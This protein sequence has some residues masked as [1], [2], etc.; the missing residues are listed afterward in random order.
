MKISQTL[1]QPENW[2]DFESLCLLL[3]RAEWNSEDLK[4]NGRNGQ[5]QKGVDIC[6]HRDGENEYS[7]IQCKCKPGNKA[8]TTNEIDEEIANAQQF[9]PAIRRLIFATTADKDAT[10]EEYVRIKDDE[11]R[12]KGLFSIDIKSWQDIVDLLERNKN[13]LNTYLDIVAEDY[14]VAITFDNGNEETVI[15]PKFSRFY[16][17]EP[18]V[19][20]SSIRSVE[21]NAATSAIS[22][23]ALGGLAAQTEVLSAMLKNHLTPV[24]ATAR[25]VRGHIKT[26]HAF[27]PL[28]LQI[29]NQGRA[30]IDDYKVSFYF[31]NKDV[32]F[33]KSNVEKKTVM[34]EI[35]YS[36]GVSNIAL[37]NGVGLRMFGSSIIPGDRDFSD[38]F[39]VHFPEDVKEVNIV[40]KL[41]SRQYSME[42]KLRILV[43]CMFE[44]VVRYNK[45]KA[46][47]TVI[48]DFIER[49]DIEA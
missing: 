5:A 15:R 26:N 43:E 6:G 35:R 10:I 24:K 41:L 34:P 31:D 47:E 46:G 42:G 48:E 39:Y 14:Q 3:W 13:V 29:V 9:K 27:C 23:L 21:Q 32:V 11:N 8:L 20:E 22:K 44:E 2:Q 30:P 12:Q 17:M 19:R 37:E 38:D 4:K 40:W 1:R 36:R 49:E 16:Y 18:E 7:G 25:V 33:L 28:K 45:E